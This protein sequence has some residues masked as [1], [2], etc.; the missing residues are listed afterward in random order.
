MLALNTNKQIQQCMQKSLS[1]TIAS[2][3]A[4]YHEFIDRKDQNVSNNL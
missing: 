4:S 2:L 3:C 1:T